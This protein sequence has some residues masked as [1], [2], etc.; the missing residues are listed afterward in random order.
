MTSTARLGSRSRSKYPPEPTGSRIV[1]LLLMAYSGV[2]AGAIV[3]PTAS[4]MATLG[5][6]FATVFLFVTATTLI[7]AS[8]AA[9]ALPRMAVAAVTAGVAVVFLKALGSAEKW[10]PVGGRATVLAAMAW[11]F[12]VAVGVAARW[13]VHASRPRRERRKSIEEA[14]RREVEYAE[15]VTRTQ[16]TVAAPSGPGVLT[17]YE[18][19]RLEEVVV[20][21]L[22][23]SFGTPGLG[24]SGA[25]GRRFPSEAVRKGREGELNFARA[26]VVTG[27]LERF[28]VFWSVHVPGEQ[29]GPSTSSRAD[30]DCV[31]ATG[32]HLWLVDVKNYMQGDLTWRVE[33]GRLA[34]IDHRTGAYIG[35]TRSMGRNMET[36][37]ARVRDKLTQL[38]LRCQ[39]RPVVVMMPTEAGMG[40][41]ENVEWPGG[42]PAMGL[43]EFLDLL[44]ADKPFRPSSRDAEHLVRAFANLVKDESGAAPR[45]R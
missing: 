20:P 18:P 34:A 35:R 26:L 17:G 45:P 9:P 21:S 2:V 28:A 14:R 30:I 33:R 31:I 32:N 37:T 41:I 27:L 10:T 38:G 23:Y 22:P 36:S 8:P 13:L 19:N 4:G 42:I 7:E 29:A 39:V 6:I 3:W 44:R 24:L 1:A 11:P 40:R 25:H 15:A 5:L 12:V 16:N 43:P